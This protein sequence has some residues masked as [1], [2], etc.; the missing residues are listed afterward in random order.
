MARE[1]TVVIERDEQGYLVGSVPSLHGCH[2]QSRTMDELIERMEEAI[3]L[4]LEIQDGHQQAQT[5]MILLTGW[6]TSRSR[7]QNEVAPAT[8]FQLKPLSNTLYTVL[9]EQIDT[10][11]TIGDCSNGYQARQNLL[12]GFGG[13]EVDRL[14]SSRFHRLFSVTVTWEV[15]VR[16]PRLVPVYPR[17]SASGVH[18]GKGTPLTAPGD[19]GIAFNDTLITQ[20]PDYLFG[21]LARIRH[22]V[23][24]CKLGRECAC[25]ASPP[26]KCGMHIC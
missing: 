26:S 17:Q 6:C 23:L 22:N 20:I 19:R 11:G 16:P 24:S 25:H 7:T 9:N 2:T 1:F 13:L 10:F 18:L 4:C 14:C 8:L 21:R 12:L 3:Q 15:P 5:P